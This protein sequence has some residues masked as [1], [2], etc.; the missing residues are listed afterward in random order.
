[1]SINCEMISAIAN[2]VTAVT[3]MG[4]AWRYF[5]VSK[6]PLNLTAR[7]PHKYDQRENGTLVSSYVYS[8]KV[9][10]SGNVDIQI[11]KMIL[12]RKAKWAPKLWSSFGYFSVPDAVWNLKLP[13]RLG[14]GCTD[15]NI[16][17]GIE[18]VD[19]GPHMLVIKEYGSWRSA[20]FMLPEL[21]I[22]PP[23]DAPRGAG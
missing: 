23:E 19:V 3:A 10:N 22:E 21:D 17:I 6:M 18:R 8:Y 13:Y 4:S 20:K 5:F 14:A 16:V 1:M 15:S 12:K 11:S 7:G 9:T 2:V